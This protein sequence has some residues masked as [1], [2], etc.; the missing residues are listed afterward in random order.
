MLFTSTIVFIIFCCYVIVYY[1][2]STPQKYTFFTYAPNFQAKNFHPYPIFNI[3]RSSES[4]SG[5][6]KDT[7]MTVPSR[8][9]IMGQVTFSESCIRLSIHPSNQTWK[10]APPITFLMPLSSSDT[11]G[12][13]TGSATSDTTGMSNPNRS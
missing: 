12:K 1:L 8:Y 7:V 11:A 6:A 5:L 13:A 2:N 9:G 3:N 4:E 10:N